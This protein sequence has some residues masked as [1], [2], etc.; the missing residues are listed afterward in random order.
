MTTYAL[1]L[2]ALIV[3]GI[4]LPSLVRVMARVL[5]RLPILGAIAALGVLYVLQPTLADG[6]QADRS[7]APE[8][9]QVETVPW[10]EDAELQRTTADE[11]LADAY[12]AERDRF[13]REIDAATDQIKDLLGV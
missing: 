11:D 1:A 6:G 5:D 10:A 2:L 7:E 3:A 9:T 13:V 12:R 4:I 8:L